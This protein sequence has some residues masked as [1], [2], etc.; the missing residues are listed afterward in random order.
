MFMSC[1]PREL[2]CEV[3]REGRNGGCILQALTVSLIRWRGSKPARQPAA[4]ALRVPLWPRGEREG[5]GGL[6]I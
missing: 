6:E 1:I 5:K 3:W 2:I 4:R